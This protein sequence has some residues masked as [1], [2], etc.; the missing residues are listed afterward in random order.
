MSKKI[1]FLLIS[2]IVLFTAGTS[3]YSETVLPEHQFAV[4][5]WKIAGNRLYQYDAEQGLA[6]AN[7]KI[8]QERTMRYRFNVRFEGGMEDMHGGFGIHVFAD[9]AT[10]RASWGCGKSYL[11]WLNFDADPVLQ[12]IPRGLSAQV[13]KSYSHSYME[14]VENVDLNKYA[15]ILENASVDT[16]LPIDIVV[17]GVTGEVRVAN[18]LQENYYFVLNLGNTSSLKGNWIALRTNG[19]AASFGL[20]D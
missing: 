20:P 8:P 2:A 4:G 16:V 3:V 6:K 10:S 1:A 7:I 11:L 19:M 14:L 13:Y 17:N 15:Y 5:N 9:S 18:P 12:E